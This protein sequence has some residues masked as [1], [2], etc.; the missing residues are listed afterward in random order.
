MCGTGLTVLKRYAVG[1]SPT[2]AQPAISGQRF[3][4]KSASALTLWTLE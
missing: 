1:S 3:F 4:I 2:W